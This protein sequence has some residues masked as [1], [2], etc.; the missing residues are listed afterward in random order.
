[1]LGEL[2]G[3]TTK[4]GLELEGILFRPKAKTDTVAVFIH[5][6]S[7]SF[8]HRAERVNGFAK[9]LVPSGIAFVSFD[10]RGNAIVS[11]ASKVDRR[12]GKGYR[13]ILIGA[14]VERFTDSVYDLDAVVDF[15]K[16]KGFSKIVLMGHS[17]GATKAVYYL[18]RPRKQ[19]KVAG[20]ILIGPLSDIPILK[21]E[22]GDNFARAVR[23]A[24]KMVKQKKTDEFMPKEVISG[25][26][27]PGRFLSLALDESPESVFPYSGFNGPLKTFSRIKIPILVLYSEKDEHADAPVEELAQAFAKNTRSR[28]FSYQILPGADHSFTGKERQVAQICRSWI[29][30]IAT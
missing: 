7:S 11:Q 26:Y 14:G 18:S 23:V 1:M 10:T 6:L 3:I 16:R 20:V 28:K 2:C 25:L 21:K 13:S 22:L 4:D 29:V 9:V 27:T 30:E 24:K 8:H 5:G 17:T 12:K 19:E 15:L